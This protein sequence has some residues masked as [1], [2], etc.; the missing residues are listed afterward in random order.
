MK[1]E[2]ETQ[3]LKSGKKIK[4]IKLGWGGKMHGRHFPKKIEE[5]EKQTRKEK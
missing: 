1:L 5:L 4:K 2:T 3:T